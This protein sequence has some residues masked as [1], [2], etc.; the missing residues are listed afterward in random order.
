M[1]GF[2]VVEVASEKCDSIA[3]KIRF[4]ITS[5]CKSAWLRYD[6]LKIFK[7]FFQI[8]NFLKFFDTILTLYHLMVKADLFVRIKK[9]LLIKKISALITL[10]E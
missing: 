5:N 10:Y 7:T 8:G 2:K 4:S 6:K 3:F 9:A 1:S